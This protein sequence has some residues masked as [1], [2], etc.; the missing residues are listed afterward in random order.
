[1]VAVILSDFRLYRYRLPLQRPLFVGNRELS[2]REGLIVVLQGDKEH[3]GIGEVAPLPGYSPETLEETVDQLRTLRFRLIGAPTPDNL[4]ELS[5][6]FDRWF[7][8][9]AGSVRFGMESAVLDLRASKSKIGIDNLLGGESLDSVQIN[10]LLDAATPDLAAAAGESIAAGY[11][12]VKLKVGRCDLK[13]DIAAVKTV[14]EAVGPDVAIR[15]D[16]NQRFTVDHA[17]TFLSETSGLG[18][19]Y[20]EEPAPVDQ[21]ADLVAECSRQSIPTP[22]ARDESLA[23]MSPEQLAD[24][25]EIGAVVLKPSLIGLERSMQFARLARSRGMKVVVSA[26]FESSSAISHLARFA[27][28]VMD[29]RTAAG[30]DTIS[31]LSDD[32]LAP[33]VTVIEGRIHIPSLPS[34]DENMRWGALREVPLD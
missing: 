14:R 1:L 15:L 11:R 28:A 33:R 2:D 32:V 26:M 9:Y 27:A 13:Q 31:W 23:A 3:T 10:A 7:G 12:T 30:L 24:R 20:L 17:A 29:T 6:G 18:I 22:L 34:P 4:E 16:A 5:G 21:L 8:E 25:P 19:E